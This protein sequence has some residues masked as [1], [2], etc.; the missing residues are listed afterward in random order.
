VPGK[1]FEA[2]EAHFCFN[3]AN[4]SRLCSS[5]PIQ[6]AVEAI[7]PGHREAG[8][9]QLIHGARHEPLAVHPKLQLS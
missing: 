5:T 1:I 2:G 4:S 6:T 8:L 3:Q 7:L 9:Q